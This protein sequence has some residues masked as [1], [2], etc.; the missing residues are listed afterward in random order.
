LLARLALQE[1]LQGRGLGT[2]LLVDA[3]TRAVAAV[4]AV[5]GRFIVVDAIDEPASEFYERH[6]FRRLPGL[7]QRL[8]MKATD[9]AR[10]L[11]LGPP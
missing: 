7:D 1:H 3:L 4:T 9:A 6:G 8:V 10:S 5:G 11:G 2:Q